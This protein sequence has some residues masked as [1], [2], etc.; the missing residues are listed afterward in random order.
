MPPERKGFEFYTKDLR[1]ARRV[2]APMVEG[3][4]LAW[5]LLSRRHGADLCYTP[6]LHSGVFVRDEKYRQEM[7]ATC[8]EDR[9]LIVQFCANDPEIFKTAVGHTVRM[10]ECDAV[11]LNLGCPQVIAKRGH[12]GSFLQ[13]EWEL[14]RKMV[15]TIHDN[16]SLPITCKV[17]IFPE[18]QRSIDYAKMLESAGCQLL[19]V[20]GRTREQK[21][22][23][24]GLADWEHIA[25]VA[26]S[27]E[28]PVFSNG[29]I[30]Y[31]EDV[32]RC[33]AFTGVQGVMT[34]EGNLYNPAIFDL[35]YKDKPPNCWEMCTE[36]LDL[37]DRYPCPL[38]YSR[39]HVFKMLHHL[40]QMP[41]NFDVREIVAKA[42]SKQAFRDAVAII[43]SRYETKSD[44]EFIPTGSLRYPP[45]KCQPYVRPP[46]EEY[47]KKM[48]VIN[49]RE[50]SKKRPP[51]A[52]TDQDGNS[53]SPDDHEQPMSKRK[54]KK[55][56]RNP[57]LKFKSQENI[58]IC[59]SCPNPAGLK[60]EF[61][62]CRKCCKEKCF[63]EELDCPGHKIQV[64]SK[65]EAARKASDQSEQK[66]ILKEEQT[67][68]SDK[69]VSS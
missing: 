34:A 29:N 13:D 62:L 5:R 22:P 63:T 42:K 65:R 60:C 8:P 48:A 47:V 59:L 36:Y 17:R 58:P 10:I 66:T 44:S 53:G 41:E 31:Y 37:V 26:R 9:P 33:I 18:L 12:F 67:L 23:L 52:A 14:L 49:E 15:S 27:V 6:M 35:S 21:G 39:G 54:Q 16:F 45:W 50:K 24:T 3:S 64:K 19:T 32:D 61:K 40:L 43:K 55:L 25:A 2:V 20:H 46:P 28:I 1:N 68:S 56:E 51:E 30:Q 7:L 38:S 4:E 57:K 69:M 11:D